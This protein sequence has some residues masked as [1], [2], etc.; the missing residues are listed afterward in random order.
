MNVEDIKKLIRIET[1][2]ACAE[3]MQEPRYKRGY[4]LGQLY[5]LN[6]ISD[7]LDE[8]DEPLQIEITDEQPI[9]IKQDEPVN[10]YGESLSDL[11]DDDFPL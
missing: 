5:M 11:S 9:V 1:K 6:I 10:E 4:I 7:K 8:T 3:L 2:R